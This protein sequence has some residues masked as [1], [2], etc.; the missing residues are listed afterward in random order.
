M[1]LSKLL[2]TPRITKITGS[3]LFIAHPDT[4][5]YPKTQLAAAIAIGGTAATFYDNSWLADDDWLLF[6]KIGDGE[7]EDTD[8]NG[9]VTRGQ[10]V[11]LTNTLSFAHGL[12]TPVTKIFERGL[13]IYGAATD[14]GAGTLI[15]SIDA[16]TASGRQLADA[17]MIKWEKAETDY[18]LISSDTTYAYYFAKFTDGTTDSSASP[19]VL[20]AGLV[21]NTI[22]P[23]IDRAIDITNSE[24]DANLLTR[25][26]LVDW[27]QDCQ[28]SIQ[29]FVYQDP[30]SGKFKQK[31]WSFEVTEDTSIT[32]AEGKHKYSLSALALKY[33]NDDRAI[34]SVQIGSDK[35]LRKIGFE[36]Y[37]VLLRGKP[38]TE[39][40]VA[41]T[42]G[43]TS[44]TVDSTADFASA[45]SLQVGTDAV[46]YT[47]K[48]S[49]TFTGIPAS[50]TGSITTTQA[51][52]I[53]V[54]QNW[55]IGKMY[56]YMVVG[57][58][59]YFD[60]IP[61]D[62]EVGRT[63]H[64]RYFKLLTRF[65]AVSDTTTISFTNV[66]PLYLAAKIETRKGNPDKA[67]W[68]TNQWRN[69]MTQC[70]EADYVPLPDDYRYYSYSDEIYG[71]V[72]NYMV[73]DY[74]YNHDY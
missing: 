8:I 58:N 63:V 10:S 70:A 66:F 32:L 59:L 36:D 50:G 44:I 57:G 74:Y 20:A 16:K 40:S 42:A 39:L 37:D 27:A 24:I 30:V 65:T 35:P 13:K 67:D 3:T 23:F 34:I 51:V 6:G 28:E 2:Q 29:Q 1:A 22:E 41:A 15:A 73:S 7:T 52:D 4:S 68:Y 21:Y 26:M 54:T 17:Q 43:V 61:A 47:A 46:T 48:T 72:N 49:T 5:K 14:G 12:D 18:T 19:Y 31:D 69:Q 71:V 62:D 53:Q 9:T 56:K 33:P 60:H 11:T 55:N 45:G 38:R 64:I 25:E